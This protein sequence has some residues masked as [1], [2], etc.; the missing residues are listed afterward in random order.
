MITGDER[1]D[2]SMYLPTDQ[3]GEGLDYV[4]PRNGEYFVGVPY[5]FCGKNSMPFIEIQD[6]AGTVLATVNAL[7]C[8]LIKF[9]EV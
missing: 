3:A 4:R 9:I 7:D 5:G 2:I 8:H 1:K 6:A